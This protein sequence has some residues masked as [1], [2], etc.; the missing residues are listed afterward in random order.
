MNDL[1]K[2]L[3]E[4]VEAVVR[5]LIWSTLPDI[6]ESAFLTR[7]MISARKA[8]K[9]REKLEAEGRHIPPFLIASITRTCNLRCAGCYDQ[10][11][12]CGHS[13][14]DLSA[15]AWLSIFKQAQALGVSFILLAGGEPL[16]RPDV[17]EAATKVPGILFP[18]FTNATLVDESQLN[19]F[20]GH[21]NL[22][23][24][25]SLEGDRDLTDARRGPG[26]YDRI[27][28]A[29]DS[30]KARG[31]P[32]GSSVTVTKTNLGEVTGQSFIRALNDR[33]AR[34]MIYVEYV[35]AGGGEALVPGEAERAELEQSLSTLRTGKQDAVFVVSR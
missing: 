10:N 13:G 34:A 28:R 12:A 14:P 5:D 35:P 3:N 18:V 20:D 15:E 19:L 8:S 9:L 23:P 32:F 26:V 6:K 33:G 21:R 11:R 16:M 2:Q 27:V 29:M 1:L 4:G 30:F 31:I 17:L 25:I 7:F 24:V 22:L